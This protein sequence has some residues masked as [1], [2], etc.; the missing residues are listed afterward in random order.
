MKI[1]NFFSNSQVEKT[2]W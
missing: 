1:S 2:F